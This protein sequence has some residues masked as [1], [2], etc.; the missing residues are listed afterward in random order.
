VPAAAVVAVISAAE[1]T[2]EVASKEAMA[3]PMELRDV[4]A[5]C[6][7]C[8]EALPTADAA[9]MVVAEAAITG[10]TAAMPLASIL[11]DERQGRTRQLRD[12]H[13]HAT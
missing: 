2:A 6:P 11:S 7:A 12:C 8:M 4:T 5:M 13:A 1:V 10:M 9:P 3:V